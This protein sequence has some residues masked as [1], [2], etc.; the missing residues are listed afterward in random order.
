MVSPHAHNGTL[1]IHCTHTHTRRWR[2]GQQRKGRREDER[3]EGRRK[4][5]P[6]A[7]PLLS[8]VMS[9]PTAADDL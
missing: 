8:E 4:E 6:K 5:K 1:N 3:R 9:P 2:W 7:R